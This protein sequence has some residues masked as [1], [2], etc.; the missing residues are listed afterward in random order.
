[1]AD[2]S[3]FELGKRLY[4]E[5][6]ITCHGGSGVPSKNLRFVVRP[7][8]LS[9]TI[10]TQEQTYKIIKYGT[11]YWG[12][13]SD[14]M[15]AFRY[16]YTDK[17]IGA[18]AYYVYINFNK[19]V[20]NRIEKLYNQSDPIPKNKRSKMLKRGEKVYKRNCSWCHGLDA[21]GNGEATKNPKQ[22][23]FPYDLRKT[24]LTNKQMFLY[25]KYGGHYWGTDKNDMPSWS[26]KYDDF[27][28]K[29]VVKYIDFTFRKNKTK[30][31][32]P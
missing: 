23:I 10:L 20:K 30:K 9:K 21:R 7:R 8:D 24:L 11:H 14:M 19:N 26:R 4:T 13:C 16:V 17:E 29:S 12:S 25:A 28:L 15:P 32:N 3:K 22:S 1:M 2:E 31:A 18:I 5:A 27:T 6:C